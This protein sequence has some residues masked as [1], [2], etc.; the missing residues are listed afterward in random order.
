M[1][2]KEITNET[3][4]PN[5]LRDF[6]HHLLRRVLEVPPRVRV[7]TLISSPLL[8]LRGALLRLLQQSAV[9]RAD[10]LPAGGP[11]GGGGGTVLVMRHLLIFAAHD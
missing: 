8:V 1:P 7:S 6:E 9:T 5:A 2:G 11:N 10:G 4:S 3:F